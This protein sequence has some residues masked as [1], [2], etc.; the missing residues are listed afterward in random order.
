MSDKVQ[1]LAL[2]S[3]P[4]VLNEYISALGVPSSKWQFTDVYGTDPELLAM[5]PQPT[6]AL[7]LLYPITKKVEEAESKETPQ[8]QSNV[9]YMNQ[10]IGNACGTIAVIHALANNQKE[11]GL[12]E[13]SPLSQFFERTNNLNAHDRAKALEEAKEISEAHES[14][15]QQG[16]T[17][18]PDL[19]ADINLHFI[20][21]VH[22]DGVLYELDGRKKNPVARGP[23][24][25]DTLLTDATRVC[26]SFM[27]RDPEQN[28]F[29]MIALSSAQ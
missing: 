17:E 25:P 26:A 8:E 20:A 27:E 3:N 9:W 18:T 14:T 10:Y 28:Q 24:T 23:T 19:H 15:A 4:D 16:Q 29:S 12:S 2:E 5:V 1:W 11:L 22:R 13:S 7:L 6:I 21:F